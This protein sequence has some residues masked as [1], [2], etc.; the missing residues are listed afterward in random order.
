MAI[1]SLTVAE[2]TRKRAAPARSTDDRPAETVTVLG[3]ES[4]TNRALAAAFA[5]L[6]YEALIAESTSL[7][8]IQ[9]GQ[10]VLARL[11]ACWTLDRLEP[12]LWKLP[13]LEQ[14]GVKI[15][16]GPVALLA[17]HDKLSAA[18]L[19]TRAGV[20]QPS[21]AHVRDAS[22]PSFPP[23]Y[24]VKPRFGSRGREIS[25]CESERELRACLE[26]L[27]QRHWFRRQGALVQTLVE[28]SAKLR[29][30]VAGG[31]VVGAVEERPRRG[32]SNGKLG[33]HWRCVDPPVSA[34]VLALRAV[35][36]LG[37]DLAR[38]EIVTDS[39]GRELVLGIDGD[40][41]LDANYGEH[42]FARTAEALVEEATMEKTATAVALGAEVANAG[43]SLDHHPERE[44]PPVRRRRISTVPFDLLEHRFSLPRAGSK[45][46]SGSAKVSCSRPR[47]SRT[48]RA[49]HTTS[50]R[51]E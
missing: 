22:V 27:E 5:H 26:W 40:A 16:N 41:E 25:V 20:A 45:E 3:R 18:L 23:P 24:I 12:G 39:G 4:A 51:E 10:V 9:P 38:V 46:P 21:T 32:R 30:V 49:A 33:P 37:L 36:A 6:G 42:V 17:A 50:A 31:R 48:G 13:P 7:L 19:L 35:A 29:T 28:P 15:L 47:P 8:P 43:C 14:Q 11:G 34:R 2:P 1:E 44:K